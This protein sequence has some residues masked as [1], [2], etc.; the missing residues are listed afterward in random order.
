MRL[1]DGHV[2]RRDVLRAG[3]AAGAAMAGV[4]P[5][6]TAAQG[7]GKVRFA[8]LQLG[9]A[10]CEIIHKEDLLGKRGWQAEY[11]VVPGSPAG[12]V[13]TF[14]AGNVDAIDMS[15][16]LAAKI[17]ED[18]VPMK[19]TGVA[20]AVLGAIVARKDAGI[21]KVEDLKGRKIAAVVGTTTFLDIRTLTLKGYGFDIQKDTQLITAQAPPDMA[22]MLA[23]KDVDAVIAWQPVSD[24]IVHRGDGVYLV[25]QIDLW[26]KATGRPTGF[27][28]HVCYVVN[29]SFIEKHPTFPKDLNDAQREA[30]ELW[31][32]NKA[33]AVEIAAEIT[34]LP[35]PVVE[36][37]HGQTVQMLHGLSDEQVDTLL[38]QLRLIKESGFLKSDIWDNPDR[39]RK[40]FFWRSA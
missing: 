29:P 16:A 24:L 22:T 4:L 1:D 21:G 30:V 14:A 38:V 31:N 40:E 17:F 26:R 5:R 23:K 36:Y 25:K 27:P 2:R 13:N 3:V 34:K 37:A 10:A 32:G 6:R 9:W 35:T 19:V 33:K 8:Y 7:K 39:V 28:V 18:G 20:T 12:L 11:S 15:F